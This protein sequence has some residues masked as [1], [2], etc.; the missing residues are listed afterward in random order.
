M[1]KRLVKLVL[2]GVAGLALGAAGFALAGT[3]TLSLTYV[4]P[5]PGTLTVPWGDTLRIT[6]VDSISHSLIS[7][8]PELQSGAVLPGKTFTAT[9]AG[10]ARSYGYRQIGGRGYPG[11]L[12]VDF[13]G[14]RI[15]LSGTSTVGFG[16]AVRLSGTTSVRSTPVA[17]EVRRTGDKHWTTLAATVS[18]SSGAYALNARLDRGGKLRA[19]MAAGHIRSTLKVVAVRPKVTGLRRG[20]RVIGKVDPAMAVSRL[21]LECR[22]GPGRWKQIAAKRPGPT[23]IVSFGIRN[24]HGLV[25]VAATR[26]NVRDGFATQASRALSAAC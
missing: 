6:N 14:G 8:H 17:I 23:G 24:G 5:E 2:L 7:S 4:G 9:I 25:R 3:T 19:T 11:K 26:K 13:S 1:R 15:S 10:P 16:R 18:D 21:A 12:V 20:G 22:A